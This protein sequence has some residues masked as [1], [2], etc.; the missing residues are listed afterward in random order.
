MNR[1]KNKQK[2]FLT[3]AFGG[4]PNYPE[5]NLKEAHIKLVDMGLS[6]EHIDA[7]IENLGSYSSR[8]KCS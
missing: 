3:F 8:A 4:A 1:Q 5:K 2:A 7:V 6:D